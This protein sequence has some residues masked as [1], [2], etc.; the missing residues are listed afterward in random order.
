MRS[1]LYAVARG[2]S[3][4]TGIAVA[5]L[6]RFVKPAD[7]ADRDQHPHRDRSCSDFDNNGMND[8]VV[9]WG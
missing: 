2:L 4:A 3:G 7:P 8:V 6:L 1:R 9:P 5:W